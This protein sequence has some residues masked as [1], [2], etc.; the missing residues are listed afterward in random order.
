VVTVLLDVRSDSLS[1]ACS[2]MI[3]QPDRDVT[4]ANKPRALTNTASFSFHSRATS[5]IL[6]PASSYATNRRSSSL[7]ALPRS[8]MSENSVMRSLYVTS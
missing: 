1:S 8:R 5:L 4:P 2:W 3:R 6:S 7:T